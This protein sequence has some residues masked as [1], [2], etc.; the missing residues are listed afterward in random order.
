MTGTKHGKICFK[1]RNLQPAGPNVPAG[2]K[3]RTIS[4]VA[5]YGMNKLVGRAA[6]NKTMTKTIYTNIP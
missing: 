6:S 5:R 2:M 4:L 1:S 3:H